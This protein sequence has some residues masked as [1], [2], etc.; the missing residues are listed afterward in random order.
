MKKAKSKSTKSKS[1]KRAATVKKAAVLNITFTSGIG[2][3]DAF[4]Y[5]K[6]FPIDEGGLNTSG[7]INFR[8]VKTDDIIVLDGTCSKD[9]EVTMDVDTYPK[10][11]LKFSEED[12]KCLI[13]VL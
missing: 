12:I 6:G 1:T 5:R 10:T 7:D 3:L 2:K 4:Q 13:K 8:D 11:P 9:A